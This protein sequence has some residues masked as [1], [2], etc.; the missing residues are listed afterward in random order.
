MH[1]RFWLF[2]LLSLLAPALFAQRLSPLAA[3]P[4]WTDLE[5]FH[6][7]LTR[8]EFTRLLETVYAPGGAARG[9]IEVQEDHVEILKAVGSA[10]LLAIRLAKDPAE[11]RPVPRYWRT[12]AELGP[13]APRKP[14]AGIRIALDPGHLGGEWARMEAR[15][16]RIGE[17]EPVAEGDMALRVAQYLAPLLETLGAE[18]LLVR[19]A[20]GPTT[21]A[22]PADLRPAA[23]SLLATMGFSHPREEYD[24]PHDPRL[25]STVQGQ[26]ELLF[27]RMHEIRNR[28]RL[29]NEELQP[30][31]VLCLHFN[32]EAWGA[33]GAPQFSPRNHLHVLV[34][35]C[36]SASELRLDDVRHD[37]LRRLLGGVTLPEQ[38][39]ASEVASVFARA[40][41]L[42]PL[43]YSGA[44]AVRVN[45]SPYLWARNLLANRLYR[46]PVVYLEPYVMNNQEVWERVQAGDYEGQRVVA[47]S[48]RRSLYR[49]YAAAVADGLA[50]YFQNV[51]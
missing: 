5:A 18:V 28:A 19:H 10:E 9:L 15:W 11:V 48:L 39:V 26:S 51:R 42:P 24:N 34:N 29:V 41:A 35:G 31:L 1:F 43:I 49:E 44:N 13:A 6:E 33:A 22:R 32:A 36:Y 40:A 20:P 17:S 3:P 47:G 21:S 30:D 7:A 37:L 27:Y 50:S 16:F 23:R 8:E 45:E 25:G 2:L 46:C 14:L 4:D 12:L 38:A